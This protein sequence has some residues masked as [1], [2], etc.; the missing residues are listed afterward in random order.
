MSRKTAIV[1]S[2]VSS[3]AALGCADRADRAARNEC[4]ARVGAMRLDFEPLVRHYRQPS[5]TWPISV[6][7]EL[8]LDAGEAV[9]VDMIVTVTVSSIYVAHVGGEDRIADADEQPGE[10]TPIE[11]VLKQKRPT[12]IGFR[13]DEHA[14]WAAVV[15]AIAAGEAMDARL[16][17]LALGPAPDPKAA[18]LGLAKQLAEADKS[19]HDYVVREGPSMSVGRCDAAKQVLEDMNPARV[20]SELP[21]A[22]EACGCEGIDVTGLSEIIRVIMAPEHGTVGIELQPQAAGATVIRLAADATFNDG[23]AQ[24]LA[25]APKVRLESPAAELEPE[26]E[27]MPEPPPPPPPLPKKR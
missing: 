19:T 14:P 23:V 20:L 9:E 26:P 17:L 13:I 21:D 5:S 16:Y 1:I 12:S 7:R 6:P 4:P 3:L 15:G 22:I 24:V 18:E 25:A 27:P 10:L 8:V 11:A 2:L